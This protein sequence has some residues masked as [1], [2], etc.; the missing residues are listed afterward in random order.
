ML[1]CSMQGEPSGAAQAA[2]RI[3][4]GADKDISQLSDE[5]DNPKTKSSWKHVFQVEGWNANQLERFDVGVTQ[6]GWM[7]MM[8]YTSSWYQDYRGIMAFKE[9]P[10]DFV[11][12]THL[13][14][15]RRG[16]EG[17]PRTQFSLAGIMVREPR[18]I[19]PQ[20][21]TPGRE[22]YVFLSTGTADKPG[23]YQ[24]EVK[25][26]INSDS[27]LRI[28]PASSGDAILQVARIGSYLI[29]L[30]NENGVWSVHQRY[31]HPGLSRTVQAGL[32]CYTDWPNVSKLSPQQHNGMVIRNGNPDLVVLYDYVR[33]R[34]P[35]VPASWAGKPLD[36]PQSVS[37]QELLQY[38]GANAAAR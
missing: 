9:V 36:N 22:N 3:G 19:T 34:R 38:L 17:P 26:T 21:W 8:P 31:N 24:F 2:Q 16:G 18:D 4:A 10:G 5:F 6:P 29:L 25:T 13:R 23:S 30:K 11:M 32:T 7:L 14:V 12:T 27:Q 1:S 33:Y 20:T 28:A 15:N 37:D 35:K